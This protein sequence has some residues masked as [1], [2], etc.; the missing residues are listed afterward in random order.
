[1]STL[2]H[3]KNK[4]EAEEAQDKAKDV[5]RKVGGWFGKKS[6]EAKDAAVDA[7]HA[8]KHHGGRAAVRACPLS[9]QPCKHQKSEDGSPA[10]FGTTSAFHTTLPVCVLPVA[11]AEPRCCKQVGTA[12]TCVSSI[13]PALPVQPRFGVCTTSLAPSML[14]C[15]GLPSDS[16]N[17]SCRR[18]SLTSWETS[19]TRWETP[20]R[21]SSTRS[22][23]CRCEAYKSG[24]AQRPVH[25]R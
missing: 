3:S 6:E 22:E 24:T 7:G 9:A 25:V 20:Q 2:Q 18:M 12:K 13:G 15:T 23:V 11:H 4:K 19:P 5:G 1:M 10:Y 8:A 14:L 21:V 16:C 17:A